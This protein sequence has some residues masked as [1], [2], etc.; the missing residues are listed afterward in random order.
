MPSR[1]T[2]EGFEL[3]FPPIQVLPRCHPGAQVKDFELEPQEPPRCTG[4]GLRG[5]GICVLE[6]VSI[7]CNRT[8]LSEGA[9]WPLSH[10]NPSSPSMEVPCF[11]MTMSVG[12]CEVFCDLNFAC[13]ISKRFPLEKVTGREGSTLFCR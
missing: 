12:R 5:T 9:R 4:E 8:P 3:E 6:E 10:G 1:C 2:G 13:D 7:L 11:S